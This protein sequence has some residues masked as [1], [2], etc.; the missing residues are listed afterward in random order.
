[1]AATTRVI[2]LLLV[3]VVMTAGVSVAMP[4]Y[5]P[6][7]ECPDNW[8]LAGDICL[9]APQESG[10]WFDGQRFCNEMEASLATLAC[11]VQQQAAIGG[12][13]SPLYDVEDCMHVSGGLC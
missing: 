1:M 10:S 12:L 4:S 11:E 2:P 7:Y 13:V 8:T 5:Q 6:L 9:F 3:V